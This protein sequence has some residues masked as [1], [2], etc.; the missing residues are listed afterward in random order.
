[1]FNA[2]QVKNT[3]II[4]TLKEVLLVFCL[5]HLYG[6]NNLLT[7]NIVSLIQAGS[8]IWAEGTYYEVIGTYVL[9]Y[10]G[11]FDK[12]NTGIE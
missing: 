4:S 11:L 6:K 9:V 8:S 10:V 1:M 12:V 3:A 7:H 2:T 5:K